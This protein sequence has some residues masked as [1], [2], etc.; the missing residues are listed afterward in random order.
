MRFAG[1]HEQ[2]NCRLGGLIWL[3]SWTVFALKI[4]NFKPKFRPFLR[5]WSYLVQNKGLLFSQRFQW[6]LLPPWVVWWGNL[7]RW[8][9][10]ILDMPS[11]H[12]SSWLLPLYS[13]LSNK[14]GWLRLTMPPHII[15]LQSWRLWIFI[16]HYFD[17]DF[18]DTWPKAIKSERFH[19][20]K[21][22]PLDLT[23]CVF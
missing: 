2:V 6:C 14:I 21:R 15:N 18:L 10:R 3:P 7:L 11:H 22:F 23:I 19:Q 4:D 12:A 5:P 1:Y 13:L 17:T 20:R 8:S 9:T 16:H